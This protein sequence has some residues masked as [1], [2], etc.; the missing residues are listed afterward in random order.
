MVRGTSISQTHDLTE[1]MLAALIA[2]VGCRGEYYPPN[3]DETGTDTDTA[4]EEDPPEEG[5]GTEDSADTANTGDGGVDT[6]DAPDGSEE[7]DNP[8][9]SD[10]ATDTADSTGDP[11]TTEDPGTSN[12]EEPVDPLDPCHP[13]YD[14][15]IED[16]TCAFTGFNDQS[17]EAEFNCVEFTGVDDGGEFGDSC[18]IATACWT[19]FCQNWMQFWTNDCEGP[20]NCCT[21]FCDHNN[22]CPAGYECEPFGAALPTYIT[23]LSQNFGWCAKP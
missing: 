5:S 14:S 22:G 3:G 12:T 18:G 10:E 13:L 6:T 16:H 9:G 7:T 1:I 11:G 15:C 2:L 21:D 23:D 8:T 17:G 20:T 19:G 4:T